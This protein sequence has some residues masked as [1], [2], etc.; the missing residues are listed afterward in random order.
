MGEN[1]TSPRSTPTEDIIQ[2][3]T[4]NK[5]I[6]QVESHRKSKDLK[7]AEPTFYGTK[8]GL[9]RRQT[10]CRP[11]SF[12]SIYCLSQI[13]DANN[14][15]NKTTI[16]K[17]V[18]DSIVRSERRLLACAS[19]PQEKTLP[20]VPLQK[21]KLA[22]SSTPI[23]T[24]CRP[25]D[26]HKTDSTHSK[27]DGSQRYMVPSISR[28][29]TDNSSYGRRVLTAYRNG[30]H[31][32]KV[33]RLDPESEKIPPTTRT[34]FR[35]ARSQIRP[36]R[37]Y[38]SSNS[39]EDR[40]IEKTNKDNNNLTILLKKRSNEIAGIGK[41]DRPI[42][43]NNSITTVKNKSNLKGPKERLSRCTS[44][45]RQRTKIGTSKMAINNNNSPISRESS[46]INSHTNRR[47]SRRLG[48]QNKS[49]TL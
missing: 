13:Q 27:G 45:A 17:N 24:K 3:G 40:S 42:R 19:N 38:S 43:P 9:S 49:I 48:I 18:L 15:S 4:K 5:E 28:R 39:R 29:L 10:H 46:T 11:I 6:V 7:V 37:T 1:S 47:L 35:M 41:L 12:K 33:V 23:W 22:I 25:K 32:S 20:R 16:T 34:S 26:I 36:G 21:S 2:D 44:K 31:N 14:G 8:K 30:N